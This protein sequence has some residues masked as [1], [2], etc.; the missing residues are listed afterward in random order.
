MSLGAG[1]GAF[2]GHPLPS[3][4]GLGQHVFLLPA[5]ARKLVLF[6]PHPFS[7]PQWLFHHALRVIGRVALWPVLKAFCS[8]GETEDENPGGA[9]RVSHDGCAP[10]SQAC[11]MSVCELFSRVRLFVILWTVARQVPLSMEFSR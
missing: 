8:V 9:S 3:A 4:A 11:S 10:F 2:S 1:G 5:M 7:Q 6:S